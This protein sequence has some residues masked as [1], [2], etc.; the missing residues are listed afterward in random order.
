MDKIFH[1]L[2]RPRELRT[3]FLFLMIASVVIISVLLF[4]DYSHDDLRVIPGYDGGSRTCDLFSGRWVFDNLSYPL[5]SEKECSFVFEEVACETF[6]R[7]DTTYQNWRWQPNGCDLP[8]FN[9][10]AMLEKLRNKRLVFVGDSLNRNQWVSMV[11]LLQS[12]IPPSQ[13]SMQRH[14]KGSLVSF[15]AKDYNASIEFYWSPLL[16]ESNCDDPV[17]H[18][19]HERIIR[20]GSIKKH[21]KH[22]T[23]ADVVI[24]NTYL[25]WRKTDM[26]IIVKREDGILEET[27]M[28]QSFQLILKTWA[29]W[30]ELH[31][32]RQKTQLFFV[33]PSPT[34]FWADEW[35]RP[36]DG[37]C[38]NEVE[39]IKKEGHWGKGSDVEMMGGGERG[40][41]AAEGEGGGGA[42]DQCDAAVGVQEG[43]APLD[44][45]QVLGLAH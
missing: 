30:L 45:P 11:C 38:Y 29:K 5:Y 18:R 31:I 33:T 26:K 16:V 39:P 24:F 40:D 34:H 3:I 36:A 15:H 13:K 4:R 6:G 10:T 1:F 35:G 12:I 2:P 8:R 44:L 28:M 25:W 20:A 23:G 7:K 41:R 21:A 17:K 19:D 27:P 43:R 22:W 32:D 9:A 42:S 37:N 14:N